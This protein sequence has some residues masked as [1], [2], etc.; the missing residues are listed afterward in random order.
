M[1][2]DTLSTLS[3]EVINKHNYAHMKNLK[4]KYGGQYDWMYP[5]PGDWHI[6][7]TCSEV[8]KNVLAD[9][10]FNPLGAMGIYIMLRT[11]DVISP[12]SIC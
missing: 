10:G 9:G 1:P 7:K 3:S 8:L 11:C 2:L 4:L 6:M 5:V 12:N